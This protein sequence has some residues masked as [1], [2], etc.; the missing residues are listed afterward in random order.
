M[1]GNPKEPKL[2]QQAEERIDWYLSRY[3]SKQAA[4]LPALHLAQAEFGYLSTEV[5]ELIA[6][7]LGVPPIQIYEA[8]RFYTLYQKKPMGHHCIYVCTN[9]ACFLNGADALLAHLKKK[10]GVDCG[11]T[12]SDGKVSLFSVEC[13]A[14]CGEAPAVQI[15]DEYH[16][17]VTPGSIDRTLDE[18][19]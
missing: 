14:H 4:V 6:R 5:M 17:R 18:L 13:L 1:T 10:L 12:T 3:P 11:E 8:A 2:S 9:V 7:R 16:G 19:P 15:D